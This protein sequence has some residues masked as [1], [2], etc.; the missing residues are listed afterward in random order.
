MSQK[1]VVNTLLKQAKIEPGFTELV[2]QKLEEENQE[3]FKAYHLRLLV[4]DQ[5]VK[6]NTLLERQV[7]LMHQIC[8]AAVTS[9]PM[10]NGS[11][12]SQMHQNTACYVTDQTGPALKTDNMQQPIGT[13]LPNAFPNGGSSLHQRL[14]T[15]VDTSAHARRIDV[16]P[17]VLLAQ[18]S[19]V[20]MIPGMNGGMIKSEV[21]YVGNSQYLFGADGS[22]LETRPAIGDAFYSSF[23][24]IESNS[25]PL[26]G[27]ILDA[28]VSSIGLLGQIPRNFSL[29][30]LAA[31]F[32]NSSDILES[33]SRSPFLVAGTDNYFD[34]SDRGDHQGKILSI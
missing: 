22:V 8:P 7:E 17:N 9:L 3:F 29:S 10:S 21:G 5:I 28:N 1:E 4:K 26:N 27:T 30:D 25:Q 18:G 14:Q 11:H 2:W 20:G 19:N 33:Y 34:P 15:A 12:I 6:F 32:S 23:S 31:D 24:S 13:T 16:P